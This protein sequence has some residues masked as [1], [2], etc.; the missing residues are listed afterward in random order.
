MSLRTRVTSWLRVAL[1]GRRLEREM[2]QEWKFHLDSRIDALVAE[3]H[4][5]EEAE[6]LAWSEFGDL[7]RWKEESRQARGFG[8]IDRLRFDVRYALRQMSQHARL[9]AGG[10]GDLRPR[11]RRQ[12]GALQRGQRRAGAPATLRGSR[13]D[14]AALGGHAA[15]RRP[16][17]RLARQLPRLAR[18]GDLLRRAGRAHHA[19]R[20]G[21]HGR[22]RAVR[23]R[24]VV[25]MSASAFRVLGVRLRRAHLRHAGVCAPAVTATPSW[26]LSYAFWRQRFGAE[27][28]IVG[29]VVQLNDQAYTVGGVL[30]QG[31]DF[32]TPRRKSGCRRR[33]APA[34]ESTPLAQLVRDR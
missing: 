12:H 1:L 7:R 20:H 29:R 6:R 11:R 17:R 14:H 26:S 16:Q 18:A 34:T 9:H 5:R 4:A 3:G 2:E 27:P 24:H 31:F 30:P 33:S 23:V 21:T 10:R 25:Q 22:R 13:S 19:V 15:G 32:P 8:L 28:R